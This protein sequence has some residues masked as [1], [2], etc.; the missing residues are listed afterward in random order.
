[1]LHDIIGF[2]PFMACLFWMIVHILA[3][4]RTS[5][6][7]HLLL[8][9]IL[10][11]LLFFIDG[12]YSS[13]N[14][15]AE[16]YVW[17]TLLSQ[18]VSPSIIPASLIY[19]RS[20]KG[21]R[22]YR[23][24]HFLW[25]AVPAGLFAAT[26]LLMTLVGQEQLVEFVSVLKSSGFEAVQNYRGQIVFS[27]F[28]WSSI[29]VRIVI[30]LE[31]IYMLIDLSS[32]CIKNR[33]TFSRLW[34]F[35]FKGKSIDVLQLLITSMVFLGVVY[36]LR[37]PY[38]K[39]Y[40]D[41]HTVIM[42]L[43]SVIS[44]LSLFFFGFYAL[45][46]EKKAVTLRQTFT[47]MRF[48]YNRSNKDLI[49]GEMVEDMLG[50]TDSVALRSLRENIDR[51]PGPESPSGETASRSPAL[52]ILSLMD[53]SLDRSSLM[54]QFQRLMLEEQLY[55]QPGLSLSDVADR[56]ETNKTYISKLVNNTYN[57]GFPELLNILRIDYAEHYI[58]VHKDAKQEQIAQECGFFSA[59]S[60][61]TVFKKVTGMTP[62]V[63][64]AS[65]N[66]K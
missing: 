10:S 8:L 26:G 41:Q 21:P 61:N 37:L 27:Y 7:G 30:G 32:T 36:A 17:L 59:S 46:A 43:M 42:S 23:P 62:K 39:A 33:Y 24:V 1:M 54:G 9:L 20:Y 28:I 25:V 50:A 22:V 14:G 40:L 6:F 64:I 57:I 65:Q 53:K 49:I 55:L 58:M 35:L 15:E 63:W 66:K 48:N 19:L 4:F 34:A 44:A 47:V 13:M 11:V 38:F 60:F 31:L 52:S 56:L 16:V 3:S 12:Y 51:V 5:A 29:L 2:L 45:F 18:L